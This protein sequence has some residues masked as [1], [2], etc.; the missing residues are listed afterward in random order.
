MDF[1]NVH[2]VKSLKVFTLHYQCLFTTTSVLGT[3]V[4]LLVSWV[5]MII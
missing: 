3:A 5:S 2:L 4:L 1:F